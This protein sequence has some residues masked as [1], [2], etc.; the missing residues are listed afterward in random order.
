MNDT[1]EIYK[2]LTQHSLYWFEAMAWL[3]K[4]YE[5]LH[6]VTTLRTLAQVSCPCVPRSVYVILILLQTAVSTDVLRFLDDAHHFTRENTY[7]ANLAPLQLYVSA[8][9][10][11]PE[12]SVMRSCFKNCMSRWITHPPRIAKPWD[13]DLLTLNG[14]TSEITSMAFSPDDRYVASCA[15]DGMLRVCEATTGECVST[16]SVRQSDQQSLAIAFSPSNVLIA[17]AY[18]N[19][20]FDRPHRGF[21]VAIYDFKGTVVRMLNHKQT[22]R[23]QTAEED[24]VFRLTLKIRLAFRSDTSDTISVVTLENF[25]LEVWCIGVYS[26]DLER[27]W[28]VDTRS[29]SPGIHQGLAMS[30]DARLVLSSLHGGSLI[31]S[32]NLETGAPGGAYSSAERAHRFLAFHGMDIISETRRQGKMLVLRR[33]SAQTAPVDI[34]TGNVFAIA[35]TDN[36][37]AHISINP[38]VVQVSILPKA[39]VLKKERPVVMKVLVA[40]DGERILVVFPD[41]LEVRDVQGATCFTSP[42]TDSPFSQIWSAR[43]VMSND[44][45]VIA[46]SLDVE[47]LVWHVKSR[48]TQRLQNSENRISRPMVISNDGKSTVLLLLSKQSVPTP[49]EQDYVSQPDTDKEQ[50]VVWD[51]DRDYVKQFIDTVGAVP[52]QWATFSNDDKAILTNA[53]KF[54]LDTGRWDMANESVHCYPVQLGPLEL[55]W[56]RDW[57]QFNNEDLLWLPNHYRPDFSS[58]SRA[59]RTFAFLCHDGSAVIMKIADQIVPPISAL[60]AL[61]PS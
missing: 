15:R 40:G 55:G 30:M 17:I 51:L 23:P 48:R 21:L 52:T 4:A 3:G 33:L 56:D 43:W 60:K 6:S 22:G 18:T 61:D 34:F 45:S 47:T 53:G 12:D 49:L 36:K 7:I 1:H 14:H 11:A 44:G 27:V 5:V 32:W 26:N 37:V 50:L 31:A 8:L 2:F 42:I 28:G 20:Y 54:D 19:S 35:H 24:G 41:H 39:L 10:L 13:Y 25:M 9:V 38:G 57:I 58:Y 29:D 16:F 59:R 46:A